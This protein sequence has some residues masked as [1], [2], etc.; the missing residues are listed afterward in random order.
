MS[1][2]TWIILGVIVLA[3]LIYFLYQNNKST[4]SVST[5]QPLTLPSAYGSGIN[6]SQV[7][8]IIALF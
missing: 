1:T 2:T 6:A 8:A 4:K 5:T 7:A 3:V